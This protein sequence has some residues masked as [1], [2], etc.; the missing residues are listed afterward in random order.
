MKH[1]KIKGNIFKLF[2]GEKSVILITVLSI[3]FY[4]FSSSKL[5]I[6]NSYTAP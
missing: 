2:K 4:F 3:E 1:F 6:P 5:K